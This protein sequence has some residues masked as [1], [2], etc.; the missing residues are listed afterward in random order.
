M[1]YN[2]EDNLKTKNFLEKKLLKE[3]DQE[4][5]FQTIFDQKY[6]ELSA[7]NI[8]PEKYKRDPTCVDFNL[9]RFSQQLLLDLI[10]NLKEGNLIFKNK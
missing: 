1:A 3:H 6:L 10:Y 9:T 5:F 4:I 8:L 2:D 7:L